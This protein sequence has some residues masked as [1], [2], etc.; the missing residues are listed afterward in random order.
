MKQTLIALDQ[1]ANT[2]IYIDGDGFGYAD[3]TLSARLF[4]C[5]IQGLISDRP[6]QIVDAIF[7][8][9]KKHCYA[10]WRSEVER[11]QLPGLYRLQEQTDAD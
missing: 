6:M 2:L 4:R 1:F 7:F 8:W 3:E 11:K 5:H 9:Q 10:S